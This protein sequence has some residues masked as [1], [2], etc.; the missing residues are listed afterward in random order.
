MNGRSVTWIIKTDSGRQMRLAV[1]KPLENNLDW[2]KKR[3]LAVRY[4][5]LKMLHKTGSVHVCT[6]QH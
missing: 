1:L 5:A 2:L 6:S 3:L 4:G